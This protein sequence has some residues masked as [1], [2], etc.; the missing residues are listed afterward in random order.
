MPEHQGQEIKT[1]V[2]VAM[3]DGLREQLEAAAKREVRS[4][5]GEIVWRLQRSFER[6]SADRR[7]RRSAR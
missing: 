4:L 5:S 3:G 1:Q 2:S 6:L 7:A